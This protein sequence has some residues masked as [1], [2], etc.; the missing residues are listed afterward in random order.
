MAALKFYLDTRH[1]R[2]NGTFPLKICITQ[3]GETALISVSVFL[4]REQWD[5][6][7]NKVI[8]H[9]RKSFLNNY[10]RNRM[11]QAEAILYSLMQ[12]TRFPFLK[13]IDIKREIM[14]VNSEE[15]NKPIT[16]VE[17]FKKFVQSKNK[18][19]TKEIYQATLDRIKDF[20]PKYE[21]LLFE[22]ITKD[23][24]NKF[25]NFLSKH[26]PS[27]NARSIHF[28][29]IRAVFNDA[30]KDEITNF[31]PFRDFRIRT[32]E[33]PK[34]SLTVEQLKCFFSSSCSKTEEKHRDI[35]KLIFY[36][37]GIN[38]VDL[39]HLKDSNL[40]NGRIEYYRAKTSRLY[41]IKLEPEAVEIIHKY[42]GVNW[43]LDIMDG[44]DDY[45]DYSRLMN[46]AL[47]SIEKKSLGKSIG[48]STYWA[49]HTWA[50]IAAELDIPK[51]TISAALGHEIGSQITSIYI[52]F[53]KKKI[54]EANRKVIDYVN[55]YGK[56]EH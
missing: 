56:E 26:S 55:N 4:T 18:E 5:C 37:V 19:R 12:E 29:N 9:P 38:I 30:I 32:V 1:A 11:M 13:A 49:R 43:L 21:L 6:I 42:K 48:I 46:M 16:F 14:G 51:E 28:R 53:D 25:D 36:L 15:E 3:K 33:T 45:R 39:C 20:Y 52:N 24:L 41:S 34:R 31:Y 23:W 44:I 50:T 54:D 40:V 8:N 35:F 47:K 7:G 10:I 17:Q 2:K 22:D 27:V